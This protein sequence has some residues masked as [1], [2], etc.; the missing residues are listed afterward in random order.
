MIV[1]SDSTVGFGGGVVGPGGV[2]DGAGVVG[3]GGGVEL[4]DLFPVLNAKIAMTTTAAAPRP[5]RMNQP[6]FDPL[7]PVGPVGP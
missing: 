7:R 4:E 1:F 6:R 2:V 5:P 3:L